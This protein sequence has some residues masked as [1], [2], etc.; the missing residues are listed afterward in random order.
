MLHLRTSSGERFSG[1]LELFSA[2]QFRRRA[3][4]QSRL[5]LRLTIGSIALAAAIV[6]LIWLLQIPPH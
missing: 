6:D 5:A 2:A 4:E 1:H 3:L